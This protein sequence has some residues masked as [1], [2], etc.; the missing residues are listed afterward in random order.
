MC[1]GILTINS[2]IKQVS[3]FFSGY[4]TDNTLS[5]Q[6]SGVKDNSNNHIVSSS[7][8]KKAIP[9][10]VKETHK[11]FLAN[12]SMYEFAS[13]ASEVMHESVIKMP[14]IKT[15]ASAS[16]SSISSR[17]IVVQPTQI[18]FLDKKFYRLIGEYIPD[19]T[20]A[21]IDDKIKNPEIFQS[22]L[23]N[24][25]VGSNKARIVKKGSC[26]KIRPGGSGERAIGKEVSFEDKKSFY[27]EEIEQG[28]SKLYWI[29]KFKDKEPHL[30]VFNQSGKHD[31]M[32]RAFALL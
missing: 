14:K 2:V 7:R 4:K 6:I 17:Q 16:S 24:G 22:V 15:R 3:D 8:I 30:V 10:G 12:N 13:P 28:K 25:H 29:L 32:T 27:G 9:L 20:W 1:L 21:I 26:Y 11:E 23:A 31:K 5:T 18:D 19:N